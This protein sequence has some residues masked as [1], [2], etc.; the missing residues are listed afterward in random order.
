[1]H[2]ETAHPQSPQRYPHPRS[3]YRTHW[4][5]WFVQLRTGGNRF[6][7]GT[8]STSE[9]AVEAR[10]AFLVAFRQTQVTHEEPAP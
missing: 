1:M 4:G 3:V 9:E 10:D 2:D 7:L 8:Y 6:Y 5:T